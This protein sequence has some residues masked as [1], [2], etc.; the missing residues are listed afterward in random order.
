LLLAFGVAVALLQPGAPG[1]PAIASAF[2]LDIPDGAYAHVTGLR[3]VDLPTSHRASLAASPIDGGLL[4]EWRGGT[5]MLALGLRYFDGYANWLL[6]R[7]P[8]GNEG[9]IGEPYLSETPPAAA[10]AADLSDGAVTARQ[11]PAGGADSTEV[12]HYA[13]D[14][15]WD[16]PIRFCVNP[17]GGPPGLDGDA[18][19]ELV[20][21][22][23]DRWQALADGVLPFE[24][25][26]RCDSDPQALGDGLTT[27]GWAPD[28]GLLVAALTW[29]DV[30]SGVTSEMDTALSRGFFERLQRRDP[31]R[32][33]STCV[34]STMTHEFGHILGLEH[35]RDRT[36]PSTMQAVGASR[37]D[38]GQPSPA[39]R[40]SLLRLYQRPPPAQP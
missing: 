25:L 31:T 14:V 33:M 20:E 29:P 1:F 12:E 15:V 5:P 27:I 16:G 7:D 36:L 39:D 34:L 19:V 30:E 2:T 11:P 4:G 18:F 32:A 23:A 8:A 17:A 26:G 22:A 40:E 37:C 21:R 6:V 3:Y 10:R 35:P 9:W 38:K 24:P 28:F 13:G